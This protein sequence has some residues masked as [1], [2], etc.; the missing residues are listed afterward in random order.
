[1]HIRYFLFLSAKS[2]YTGYNVWIRGIEM[3]V[4]SWADTQQSAFRAVMNNRLG[5]ID[6]NELVDYE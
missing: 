6:S 1:M 4:F 3:A 5:S 2:K